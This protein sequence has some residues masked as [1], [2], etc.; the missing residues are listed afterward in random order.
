M[1]YMALTEVPWWYS[2][3]RG[4]KLDGFTHVSGVLVGMAGRP[5]TAGISAGAPL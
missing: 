1:F 3:G 4:S 2:A 5:S